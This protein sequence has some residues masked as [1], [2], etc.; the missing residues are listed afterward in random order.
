MALVFENVTLLGYSHQPVLL[1][2][3]LRYRLEKKFSIEGRLEAYSN[4]SG[5][6]AITSQQNLVLSGANDYDAII[7]NGISFGSGRID[8]IDFKGGTLARDEEFTYDITCY[9]DGDLFN[10]LSGVYRGITWNSPGRLD[11]LQESFEYKE[12]EKG[13]KSYSHSIS[14][15]YA[16]YISATEGVNFVKSLASIFFNATSGLG[17]YLN[18]YSGLSKTKRLYTESYNLIDCSASYTESIVIPKTS[19]GTYSYQLAYQVDLGADGFTQVIETVRIQGLIVPK[20]S[21]AIQGLAALKIGAYSRADAVYLAYDFSD[22]PLFDQPISQGIV[23][24]KFDGTIEIVTTFS[25]NP[26]YQELAIWEYTITVQRDADSYYVASEKGSITGLGRPLQNKYLNAKSFFDTQIVPNFAA[27][28]QSVYQTASGRNLTLIETKQTFEKNEFAG[29]IEYEYAYTDNSL[30]A[31]GA[32]KHLVLSVI[33]ADPVALTQTYNMFNF[34]QIVQTQNQS[35]VGKIT[36]SV[37][38]TG[39]RGT[40]ISVYLAAAKGLAQA[41]A[42]TQPD[43]FIESCQYSFSPENNSFQFHLEFIFT[44]VSKDF[45]DTTLT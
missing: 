45:T 5:V 43:S 24:N 38:M 6:N 35:S 41:N 31:R 33:V 8:N 22:A 25:N 26:K 10:A 28:I 36:I 23:E 37:E 16:N 30:F 40:D 11:T 4:T 12:D 42:P 15:R 44:G 20:F 14:V 13:E 39:Q 34:G 2:A 3:G 19:L 27:R 21:G 1:D 7:L 17:A 29:R 9:Q 32:I 18:A